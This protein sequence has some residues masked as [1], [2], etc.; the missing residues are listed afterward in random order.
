MCEIHAFGEPKEIKETKANVNTNT[1]ILTLAQL[2]EVDKFGAFLEFITVEQAKKEDVIPEGYETIFKNH[3]VCGAE[4]AIS[5]S[6]STVMC[7]NPR[8]RIKMAYMMS[9]IFSRYKIPNMG[10]ATCQKIVDGFLEDV[11]PNMRVFEM[12]AEESLPYRFTGL[13]V[14]E[15]FMDAVHLIKNKKVTLSELIQLMALPDF[16]S[17]SETIF[18]KY[19]RLDDL[20]EDIRSY[21]GIKAFFSSKGVY[22][23]KTL[24][25]FTYFMKDIADAYL[26]VSQSLTQQPVQ[27]IRVCMTG[28]ITLHGNRVKKDDFAELCGNHS[29]LPNGRR[30]FKIE[31]CSAIQSVPY[32]IADYESGSSKYLSAK[33]R[34]LDEHR[35]IIYT[36]DEFLQMIEEETIKTIRYMNEEAKTQ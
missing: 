12:F 31:I 14:E 22:N 7:V 11:N 28:N 10:Y 19:S 34:E 18:R 6:A 20:T 24:F 9:E 16:N 21:G 15:N 23:P 27:T 29:M 1:E 17:K 5:R 33:A 26:F 13:V 25:Y 3:C 32:V 36:S 35:K 2:K 4:N 30:L 8:C